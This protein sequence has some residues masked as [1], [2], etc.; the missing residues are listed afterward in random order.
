MCAIYQL[1]HKTQ[2]VTNLSDLLFFVLFC[3]QE[4]CSDCDKL[5]QTVFK[6]ATETEDDDSS[7]GKRMIKE[8]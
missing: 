6:L 3:F 5:R 1:L 2:N 8:F 4:L 7:L